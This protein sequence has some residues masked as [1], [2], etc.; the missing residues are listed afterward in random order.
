M[1]IPGG[2][3]LRG[4]AVLVYGVHWFREMVAPDGKAIPLRQ[5]GIHLARTKK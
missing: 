2:L 5:R 4:E 3:F 1:S